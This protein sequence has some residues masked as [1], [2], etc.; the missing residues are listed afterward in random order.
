MDLDLL[1]AQLRLEKEHKK[2]TQELL[3][4]QERLEKELNQTIE[5]IAKEQVKKISLFSKEQSA[6]D[7][8]YAPFRIIKGK[9]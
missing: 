6:L 9:K 5:N 1:N 4:K 2:V 8:I 7:K 3:A